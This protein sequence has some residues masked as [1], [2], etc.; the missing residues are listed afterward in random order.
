MNKT[1]F[2]NAKLQIELKS[3]H[4]LK[5]GCVMI[6]GVILLSHNSYRTYSFNLKIIEKFDSIV[7]NGQ[8]SKTLEKLISEFNSKSTSKK[9]E[10][11]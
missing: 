10:I 4:G 3:L 2:H 6:W 7:P 11:S 8:R 9:E 1:N 5:T